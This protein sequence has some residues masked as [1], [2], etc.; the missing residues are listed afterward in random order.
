MRESLRERSRAFFAKFGVDIASCALVIALTLFVRLSLLQRIESGGDPLDNWFWVKQW[1]YNTGLL[2]GYLNHHHSRFGIH[3][4]TWIVQRLFGTHPV[5]YF[6]APLFASTV[7][8]LLIYLLGRQVASRSV[9]LIAVLLLLEADEFIMASSQLRPGVF[10]AMYI[11]GAMNCLVLALAREGRQRDWALVAAAFV[12]FLAWLAKEPTAFFMPGMCLVLLV[13]GR[14]WRDLLLFAGCYAMLIGVETLAYN[15]FTQ[16]PHRAAVI[17][18]AHGRGA[19]PPR[20]FWYLLTR[21]TK[22]SDGIRLAFYFFFAA[23]LAILSSA[24]ALPAKAVV[25][26]TGSFL[27]L[28]TFGLRRFN[29]P[30]LWMAMHDRYL[31][32]GIPLALVANAIVIVDAGSAARAALTRWLAR[33]QALGSR[34]AAATWQRGL[35]GAVLALCVLALALK[36]W[37]LTRESFGH[38]AL[39]ETRRAYSLLSDAYARGLPVVG[40]VTRAPK[41]PGRG[42]QVRSLHWAMKGFVDEKLQLDDKGELP[43]FSYATSVGHVGKKARYVPLAPH[44]SDSVVQRM[45]KEQPEC[46][47]LLKDAGPNV[48]TSNKGWLMPPG[49]TPPSG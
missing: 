29:P 22:A 15:L 38:H 33:W 14:R 34:V 45:L 23:G 31:V 9:G 26:V 5:N 20:D 42:A 24:R 43:H 12:A 41:R 6:I 8:S 48:E 28:A 46:V 37:I 19:S 3:W 11:L 25:I 39:L 2:D 16:Y 40:S 36:T 13:G 17:M 32:A 18:N 1:K 49:C 27:F 4:L 10:E 47:L 30:V 35:S 7:C 44:L 21:F